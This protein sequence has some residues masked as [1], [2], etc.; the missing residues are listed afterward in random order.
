ML[1]QLSQF[2]PFVSLH[3]APHSIRQSPHQCQCPWDMHIYVFWLLY[4]LGCTL[5]PHDYS[6]TTNLYFLIPSHFSPIPMT[7]LSCSNH[8]NILLSI[9]LFLFSMF[10]IL[11]SIF[12]RYVVIA[13]L[14]FKFLIFFFLNKSL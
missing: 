5:H 3:P 4:S 12:D 7:H 2:T 11:D 13:I 10:I 6:V 9:I 1:L 8:Q 14:L